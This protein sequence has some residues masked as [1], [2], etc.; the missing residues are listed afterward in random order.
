[1]TRKTLSGFTLLEMSVVLIIARLVLGMTAPLLT[2]FLERQKQGQTQKH[3]EQIFLTLASYVLRNGRL[4]EPADAASSGE[5]TT[6]T[7]GGGVCQGYVPYHT[8]GLPETLA[9]DGYHRWMLYAVPQSLTETNV[10]ESSI[11]PFGEESRFCR[12]KRGDLEVLDEQER[13]FAFEND[14]WAVALSSG[15]DQA[16][17][18]FSLKPTKGGHVAAITRNNLMALYAHHPCSS[19]DDAEPR[20]RDHAPF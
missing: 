15:E 4:P 11:V 13:S 19:Q 7:C 1:M 12:V 14:L 20:K 6:R 17:P 10:L 18:L 16:S 5:S 8:L 9:K 3:Q 2:A